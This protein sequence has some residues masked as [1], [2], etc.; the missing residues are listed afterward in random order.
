MAESSQ[1][2]PV[3]TALMADLYHQSKAEKFGIDKSTF[4]GMLAEI[5]AKYLPAGAQAPET[6]RLFVSLR[7]EEL[8][9][10]R[11]CAGGNEKAWEIFLTR[12]RTRLYE[13]A[14]SIAREDSRARELADSIYAELYGLSARGERRASKLSYYMGRG[15]L[16]GWLRTVLAQAYVDRYRSQKRLVSL[17][18]QEEQ[19]SQFAA[20]PSDPVTPADPR[21]DQ[22]TDNAL[23]ALP[24]EDR[25]VLAA[26][27]L[28]GRTLAEIA[29]ML[30]VHESTVSRKLDKLTGNLRATIIKEL[31]ASGLDRRAAEEA[32][33]V[34]VRDVAVD[35][36]VRLTQGTAGRPFNRRE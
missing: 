13:M 10:A 19:G 26:Y 5:A 31:M 36:R 25:F 35:I 3:V 34:D 11:A 1:P 18:E 22:A 16:E 6:D 17:E 32:L 14:G 23:A 2:A 30:R 15:S 9:L 8:V 24:A 21:V 33:Q 29:R 28:D 27:F 20:A 4:A 7:V 12:Y